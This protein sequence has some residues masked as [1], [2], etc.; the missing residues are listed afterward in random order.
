MVIRWSALPIGLC[1]MAA[2]TQAQR[3]PVPKSS[4][5]G[6]GGQV[7]LPLGDLSFADT[8]VS[9]KRGT[10]SAADAHSVASPRRR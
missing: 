7:V 9:F 8:V 2:A 1:V 6:R 5:D 4:P 3:P 10:P